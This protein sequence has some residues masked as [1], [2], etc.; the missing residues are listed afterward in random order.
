MMILHI[1]GKY[2]GNKTIIEIKLNVI[3]D[4]MSTY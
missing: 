2:Q 3:E 4:Q 1:W